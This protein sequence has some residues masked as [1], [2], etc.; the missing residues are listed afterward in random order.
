MPAMSPK[1]SPKV[2]GVGSGGLLEAMAK[3]GSANLTSLAKALKTA[4][5]KPK[6]NV[7]AKTVTKALAPKA[8]VAAAVKES[9]I[10]KALV[11][12]AKVVTAVKAAAAEAVDPPGAEAAASASELVKPAP[13]KVAATVKA[14]LPPAKAVVPAKPP[15]VKAM[16]TMSKP[17][18]AKV[19]Q[20]PTKAAEA[21][22]PSA[23]LAHHLPS[24]GNARA[25]TKTI[26]QRTRIDPVLITHPML[27]WPPQ[28]Y[29]ALG[30]LKAT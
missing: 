21:Q 12:K 5:P 30:H 20:V 8:K 29:D 25:F 14:K 17:P 19:M 11:P 4:D 22:D 15:P 7:K 24:E 27:K 28:M 26:C 9:A 13:A 6:A 3:S 10:T 2:K 16:V 23:S 1:S 18:P